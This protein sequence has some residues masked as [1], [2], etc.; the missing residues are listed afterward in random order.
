MPR[1]TLPLILAGLC[2]NA[3]LASALV[4]DPACAFTLL[5]LCLLFGILG[6]VLELLPQ[7]KKS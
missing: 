3:S 1:C 7:G 6:T 2:A 4:K 5:G